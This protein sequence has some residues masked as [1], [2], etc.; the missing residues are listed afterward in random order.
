VMVA[1]KF[2][3]VPGQIA[4]DG[5]A[6]KLMVG[7][8]TG[9]TVMVMALDVAVVGVAHDELDVTIQVTMFPFTSELLV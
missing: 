9:L 5:L 1:V 8:T 2:T 7:V 3:T 4:P 6:A